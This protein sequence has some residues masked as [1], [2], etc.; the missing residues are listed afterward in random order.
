MESLIA[1][2]G[3]A[4]GAA[5]L[6][7]GEGRGQ[8]ARTPSDRRIRR[9]GANGVPREGDGGSEEFHVSL[10]VRFYKAVS[11]VSLSVTIKGAFKKGSRVRPENV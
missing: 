3:A 7:A 8:A 11:Q 10:V 6:L 1:F 4:G 9:A 5:E 2:A